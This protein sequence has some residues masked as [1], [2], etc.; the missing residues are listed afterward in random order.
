M[1]FRRLILFTI[2]LQLCSNILF[3]S[4]NSNKKIVFYSRCINIQRALFPFLLNLHVWHMMHRMHVC[5][6][7]Q[8]R[9]KTL[10]FLLH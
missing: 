10:F 4:L 9:W 5:E 2:A 1:E 3:S 7:V 8:Q 6:C